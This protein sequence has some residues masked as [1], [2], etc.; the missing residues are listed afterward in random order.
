[1]SPDEDHPSAYVRNP[2][3]RSLGASEEPDSSH[4]N[5]PRRADVPDHGQGPGARAERAASPIP[6]SQADASTSRAAP[7]SPSLV[8]VVAPFLCEV[9]DGAA[10]VHETAVPG[11]LARP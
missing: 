5:G 9:V 10:L 8:T 6:G 11:G 7:G 3:R 2:H 4:H 1:M